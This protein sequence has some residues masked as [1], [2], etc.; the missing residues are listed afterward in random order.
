MRLCKDA[1]ERARYKQR[2]AAEMLGLT[3]DQFR[4]R[5]RKYGLAKE[6]E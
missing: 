5:Y 1:L 3:Y 2:E 4:Q 6:K